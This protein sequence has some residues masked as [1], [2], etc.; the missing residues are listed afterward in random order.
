MGGVWGE[1]RRNAPPPA[2]RMREQIDQVAIEGRTVRVAVREPLPME[3]ATLAWAVAL[4]VFERYTVLDRLTVTVGDREASVS[5]N[6]V[7]RLLE[8]DDL[9]VVV[10]DRE[11]YRQALARAVPTVAGPVPPAR[12]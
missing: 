12:P 11:R 3:P 4:H 2:H 8:P 10:R 9:G 5:R 1:E 6:E 7:L